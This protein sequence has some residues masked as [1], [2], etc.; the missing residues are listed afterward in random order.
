M[1]AAEN[2]SINNIGHIYLGTPIIGDDQTRSDYIRHRPKFFT[3]S[4][5]TATWVCHL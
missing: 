3:K 5:R 2:G 1:V 4:V